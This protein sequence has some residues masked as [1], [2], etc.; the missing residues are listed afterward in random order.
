MQLEG[1]PPVV[2]PERDLDV[3]VA[4]WRERREARIEAQRA[5]LRERGAGARR[6]AVAG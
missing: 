5:A 6:S 2:T 1:G 3:E 4:A